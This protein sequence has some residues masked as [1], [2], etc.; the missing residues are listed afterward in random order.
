M[1][2][3]TGSGNNKRIIN[4][5][6]KAKELGQAECS[7]LMSLHALTGC[8]TT[9]SFKGIGKVKPLKV[10]KK[11]PKFTESLC[12][13]GDSW[14]M[15]YKYV[16]DI[17][18]F[19]CCLYGFQRF[20][21]IDELRYHIVQTKC[22]NKGALDVSKNID[23]ANLPP[24]SSTLLQHIKRTNYQVKIW[25]DAHINFHETPEPTS[26]GWKIG[27][28]SLEPLWSDDTI[29]PVELVDILEDITEYESEE[30]DGYESDSSN[31]S[32]SV[33]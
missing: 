22:S 9:S 18:Q 33:G 32:D 19:I 26:H 5:S 8:D 28:L 12:S 10:F 30:E 15:Q 13:I 29:I 24:C 16:E 21:K 20:K 4:I 1:V 11:F 25:K 23:L 31:S 3:D 14:E 17:E 6:Q 2:F 27:E 7:A